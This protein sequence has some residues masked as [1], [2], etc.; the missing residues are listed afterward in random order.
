MNPEDLVRQSVQQTIATQ[1]RSLYIRGVEVTQSTQWYQPAE[2]LNS[3]RFASDPR[4]GVR[5]IVWP[6]DN[7]I[8]MI[9][10]KPIFVRV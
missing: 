3:W 1:L 10:N 7:S 8:P 6:P 9:A 2:H 5:K 4:D